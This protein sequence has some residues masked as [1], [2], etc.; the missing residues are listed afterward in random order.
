MPAT[1]L[2]L[3]FADRAGLVAD[4]S[5]NTIAPCYVSF[6]QACVILTSPAC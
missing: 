3:R 5:V 1:L 2:V 6:R 4:G